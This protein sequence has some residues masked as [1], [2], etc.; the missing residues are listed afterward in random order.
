MGDPLRLRM[1]FPDTGGM[2]ADFDELRRIIEGVLPCHVLVE[3]QF[4]VLTW[5][6]LEARFDHWDQVEREETT[7]ESLEKQTL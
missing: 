7:W 4:T 3:Y 1:T 5:D 2:P 6:G